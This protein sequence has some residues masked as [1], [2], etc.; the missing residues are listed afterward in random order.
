MQPKIPQAV[1]DYI[2]QVT[3]A[4]RRRDA[5]TLLDLFARATGLSPQLH[6]TIIGYGTYHYRYDSGHSGDAPAAAFAP[7][8]TATVVYLNDGIAGYAPEL[9]RLGPHT[10]GVGCLY[11]KDLE[12]IDLAV[13]EDIVTRSCATLSQGTY[14]RRA[15]DA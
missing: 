1:R 12:Q 9:E 7:R 3:P 6:G 4:T 10:S 13:L 5:D 11:L 8:K 14:P 15:R 2:A